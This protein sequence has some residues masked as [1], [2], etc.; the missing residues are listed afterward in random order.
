MHVPICDGRALR[1]MTR[2]RLGAFKFVVDA[3]TL[4]TLLARVCLGTTNELDAVCSG[5]L[6]QPVSELTKAQHVQAPLHS[7]VQAPAYYVR[8]TK[9]RH[10]NL[11][12]L[13]AQEVGCPVVYMLYEL[14]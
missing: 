6:L 4:A 10:N 3:T 1:I 2:K 8:A 9:I 14:G 12:V 13:L 11:L 5:H 7:T